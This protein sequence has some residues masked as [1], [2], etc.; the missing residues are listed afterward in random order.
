MT[1]SK[2]FRSQTFVWLGLA[3]ILA[4]SCNPAVQNEASGAPASETAGENMLEYYELRVYRIDSL[5]KQEVVS[6]YLETALVPALNRLGIDRIGVFTLQEPGDDFSIFALIPYPTLDHMT[7]LS[8]VLDQD[9]EYQQGA[10]EY[11]SASIDDPAY[12]RIESKLMKAF[13]SIPVMELPEQTASGADRIFE[14]RTYESHHE[15]AAYRKVQMFDEGE[16]QIMREAGLGP[17]FFGEVLVG[18]DVPNLTYILS[19]TDRETHKKS[20]EAFLAHPDWVRMK[21][22][23]RYKDT[24]S[25]ITNWFL[26]PTSYS[27]I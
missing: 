6:R 20:W 22:M 24:V 19:S 25:K 1:I 21:A 5:E 15:N 17:V 2:F 3:M 16:T 8:D 14:L 23:E 26:V 18:H 27:Q 11:F 9:A 10:S 12:A 7:R 4:M 13:D